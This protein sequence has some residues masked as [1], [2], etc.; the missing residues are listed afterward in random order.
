MNNFDYEKEYKILLDKYTQLMLD[1][2][3]LTQKARKWRKGKKRW[4]NKWLRLSC[5]MAN[6]TADLAEK[7]N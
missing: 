3:Q 4:K 1:Y 6:Q 5:R 7:E 2:K